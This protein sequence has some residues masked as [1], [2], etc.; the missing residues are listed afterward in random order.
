[1][2]TISDTDYFIYHENSHLS[3]DLHKILVIALFVPIGC[4]RHITPVVALYGRTEANNYGSLI[5]LK[6]MLRQ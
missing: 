1:M 2:Q 4:S 3:K 6:R 5:V